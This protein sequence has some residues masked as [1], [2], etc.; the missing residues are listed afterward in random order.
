VSD[1]LGNPEK[2]DLLCLSAGASCQ[3]LDELKQLRRDVAQL[4]EQ[5][6]SD[7]LTGLHNYRYFHQTLPL[8]MERTRRSGQPLALILL[9]IDHFKKF[10]DQW[11]HELGN[12]ALIHVAHLIS[13]AVRKLDMACRF[14]GEEF[15]VILPATD[16]GQAAVVAERL[17]E[18][19]E[20]TP[21]K[22]AGREIHITASLGVDEFKLQHA[23]TP[24]MLLQRVDAWLYH[25]KAAGRNRVAGPDLTKEAIS[26]TPEEKG[27]LFSL[28]EEE[29]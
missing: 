4:S 18:M 9:D 16:L 5:A 29:L 12:R 1:M 20:S 17:R 7:A 8:E 27:A 10:N 28:W 19:V 6:H 22:D 26:V 11:G 14:G 24:E 25:A 3:Y 2:T 23:D 15:V 13:L 21:L